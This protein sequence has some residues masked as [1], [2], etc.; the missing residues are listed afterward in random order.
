MRSR[1]RPRLRHAAVFISLLIAVLLNGCG[2]NDVARINDETISLKEF[3]RQ[4]RILK[5]LRPETQDNQETRRQVLEQMVK[6]ELLTVEAKASGL[7]E[8]SA[9]Q[10]AIQ[11]QK[12][13]VMEELQAN[14]KNAQA[15]LDQLDRA[16]EQKVLIDRLLEARRGSVSVS[17]A[18]ITAAYEARKK[19]LAPVPAPALKQIRDQLLQQVILEKLVEQAKPKHRIELYPD[20]AAKGKLE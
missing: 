9:V 16:V 13:A 3:E 11:K 15:Q 19:Q 14:I 5:S 17:E 6:Q 12:I 20:V 2:R 8:D 1:F 18:E 10:E 7:A 4:L